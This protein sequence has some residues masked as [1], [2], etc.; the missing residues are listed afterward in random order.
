MLRT[1]TQL[2]L[3]SG[4]RSPGFIQYLV[5]SQLQL[6]TMG[7]KVLTASCINILARAILSMAFMLASIGTTA[8]NA[9]TDRLTQAIGNLG[10]PGSMTKTN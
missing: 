1:C 5:A 3:T 10:M 6:G 9:Q 7:M 2:F 8:A 4:R